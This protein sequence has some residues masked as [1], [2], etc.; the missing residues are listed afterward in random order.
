MA[1]IQEPGVTTVG[2]STENV[3]FALPMIWPVASVLT[4]VEPIQVCPS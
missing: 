4:A 3:P 1:V 2:R